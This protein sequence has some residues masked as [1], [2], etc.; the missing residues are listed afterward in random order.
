MD[1]FFYFSYLHSVRS[2]MSR[3]VT[4]LE[5]NPELDFSLI[6]LVCS[7]RDYKMCF[8]LNHSM[9]LELKREKNMEIS[10]KDRNRSYH[11][12]YLYCNGDGQEFRVISNNGTKGYFV[13][14]KKNIHYFLMIRNANT[15]F[16]QSFFTRLRAMSWL[17]GAYELNPE[18]LRSAEHFLLFD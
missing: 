2:K 13:P 7:L 15:S 12:N 18:K 8:E 1:P 14:E 4:R 5:L 11:V 10:D 3:K 9:G 17:E 6:A 16:L